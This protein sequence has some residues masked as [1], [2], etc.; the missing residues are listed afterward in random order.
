MYPS[1]VLDE[2]HKRRCGVGL[3]GIRSL[4]FFGTIFGRTGVKLRKGGEGELAA[5]ST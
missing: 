5:V 4:G 3:P 1:V 2:T